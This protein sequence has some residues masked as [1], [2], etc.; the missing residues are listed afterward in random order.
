MG[1]IKQ[2]WRTN[3]TRTMF[4]ETE[5]MHL[6]RRNDRFPFSFFYGSAFECQRSSSVVGVRRRGRL[7]PWTATSG[8]AAPCTQRKMVKNQSRVEADVGESRRVVYAYGPDLDAHGRRRHDKP[9][10][11]SVI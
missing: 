7:E 2:H 1:E 9:L 3:P 5:R 8:E 4:C 11:L 10:K 6:E